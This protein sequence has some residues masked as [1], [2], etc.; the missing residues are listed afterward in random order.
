[1]AYNASGLLLCWHFII[2]SRQPRSRIKLLMMKLATNAQLKIVR[3]ILAESFTKADCSSVRQHSSKPN[4][5]RICHFALP[6]IYF[7]EK[8]PTSVFV[9]KSCSNQSSTSCL[10][11]FTVSPYFIFFKVDGSF[12]SVPIK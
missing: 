6:R 1:M 9:K 4:V 5:R 7:R 12:V 3:R 8:P 11:I 10:N 2:V